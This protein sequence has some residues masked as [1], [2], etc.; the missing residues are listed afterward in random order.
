MALPYDRSARFADAAAIEISLADFVDFTVTAGPPKVTKVKAIKN[1]EEWEPKTDFWRPLRD[2][3]VELQRVGLMSKAALEEVVASQNDAKKE[4]LYLRAAAGYLKFVGR[5]PRAWFIPT[6]GLW[7]SGR[8][9]VRVNPEI[10]LEVAGHPTV[11]KLYFKKEQLTS[12]RVQ[13]SIGVMVAELTARSAPGTQ[14]GVLDVKDGKLLLP[15]G[16]WNALDAQVL[17][18]GEA[19]SFVEIWDSL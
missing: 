4:R 3:I 11:I 15:D 7:K 9:A 2:A 10:G 14:F 13:A 17:I 8:L 12:L 19:R 18:R 1:R 5:R 16:R 6:R